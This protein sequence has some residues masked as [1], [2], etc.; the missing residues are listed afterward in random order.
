MGFK[1]FSGGKTLRTPNQDQKTKKTQT[2]ELQRNYSAP[3]ICTAESGSASGIR[4]NQS[5]LERICKK[6][7]WMLVVEIQRFYHVRNAT[8]QKRHM[9]HSA[10]NFLFIGSSIQVQDFHLIKILH[11]EDDFHPS[12]EDLHL[13]ISLSARF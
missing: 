10:C 3:L 11:S 1:G 6:E 7:N 5:P 8:V 4:E 2:D 9:S 13:I 12:E